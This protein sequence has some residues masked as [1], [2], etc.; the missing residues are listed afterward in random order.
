VAVAE[1]VALWRARS[2]EL[3]DYY[4]VFDPEALRPTLRHWFL[5]LLSS[6]APARVVTAPPSLPLVAS[7]AHLRTGRWWPDLDLILSDL[8]RVIPEQAGH[9]L[10]AT[11]TPSDGTRQ[12]ARR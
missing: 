3:P 4:L 7:L 5:G 8:D 6:T 1:T 9:L 12:E 11:G 2:V 10:T